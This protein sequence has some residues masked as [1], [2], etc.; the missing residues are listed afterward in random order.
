MQPNAINYNAW[1]NYSSTGSQPSGSQQSAPVPGQ[2][3][4]V[5]QTFHAGDGLSDTDSETASTVG[6]PD[7]SDPVL[8][9]L[10]ATQFMHILS[11]NTNVTDPTTGS[12]SASRLARY[13]NS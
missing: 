5:Q 3:P 1:S 11:G 13:A 2:A 4:Q 6:E 7:Y 10:T 8:S 12:T 9:G